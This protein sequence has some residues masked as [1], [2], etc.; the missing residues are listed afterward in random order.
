MKTTY[1]KVQ[2]SIVKQNRNFYKNHVK[3]AFVMWC[4]YEGLFDECLT[5]AEIKKAKKGVLPEDLNIHHK[6]PLS[7]SMDLFVNDFSNLSVIHKTTHKFINRHIY[8]PQLRV[9]EKQP[10]GT[11]IE[12]D[13][14]NYG[15]VDVEGIKSQRIISKASMMGRKHER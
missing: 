14:P 1:T 5:K 3:R 11:E 6:I 10:F 7:G 13:I 9:L 8:A 4:A 12:I 15:Y 2:P